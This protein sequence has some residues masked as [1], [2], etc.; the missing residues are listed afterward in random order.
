MKLS[1][2]YPVFADE[3]TVMSDNSSSTAQLVGG[4]TEAPA[5]TSNA[6]LGLSAELR[7]S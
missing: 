2:L 1:Y 5:Q 3:Q 6:E 7:P 4:D